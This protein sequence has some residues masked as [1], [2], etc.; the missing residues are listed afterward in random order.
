MSVDYEQQLLDNETAKKTAIENSNAAYDKTISDYQSEVDKQ[1][2]QL[3]DYEAA[4]K[5]LLQEQTD[6]AIKQIN[7][8]QAQ[9][10][11]DYTKEQQAAYGDYKRQTDPYGANAEQMAAMGLS[12]S[13]YNESSKVAMYTAYQNRVAAAR[14]SIEQAKLTFDNAIREAKL[15][16]DINLAKIAQETLEKSLALSMESVIS[17]GDLEQEKAAAARSIDQTYYN[18]AQDIRDAQ[19]ESME[20]GSFSIDGDEGDDNG[21]LAAMLKAAYPTGVVDDVDFWNQ[22]VEAAGGEEALW[23]LGYQLAGQAT[24]GGQTE[25]PKYTDEYTLLVEEYEAAKKHLADLKA[26]YGSNPRTERENAELQ[27]AKIQELE[28]KIANY[29]LKQNPEYPAVKFA[30]E[31]A[32]NAYYKANEE[33]KKKK[34]PSPSEKRSVE[35]RKEEWEALEEKLKNMPEYLIVRKATTAGNAGTSAHSIRNLYEVGLR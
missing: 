12:R 18:R 4:Q 15:T 21:T 19:K 6:F 31:Q 33:L 27:K 2:Q 10:E 34:N 20:S 24:E 35:R 16:N 25:L 7:Q 23:A 9:A 11:K 29:P 5:D 3:K 22:M 30:A 32:K 1:Q 8:Q 28:E 14:A 13:G 26:I 17:L